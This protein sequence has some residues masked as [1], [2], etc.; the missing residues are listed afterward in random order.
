MYFIIVMFY[1]S[2]EKQRNA[3]RIIAMEGNTTMLYNPDNLAEEP[4]R[5]TFDNSYWSHDGFTEA[6]N[7]LCIA[8]ETHENG[9]HYADQVIFIY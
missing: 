9:A 2:R 8:D 3:Q 1:N 7:G 5:F 6:D 4:K